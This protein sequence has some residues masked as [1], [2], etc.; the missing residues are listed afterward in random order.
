M[1][2]LQ[3]LIG[4]ELVA[5]V[6]RVVR[7]GQSSGRPASRYALDARAGYV[8]GLELGKHQER[9]VVA[10]IG[11]VVQARYVFAADSRD[12]VDDRMRSLVE[13]VDDV[14]RTHADLGPLLG[15]GAAVP[16]ALSPEGLM[17]RSP[18]FEAWTGRNVAD[19]FAAAFDVPVLL[20]NDLNSAAL[21]EHRRGAA[22]DV[23]DVVLALVWHQVSAGLIIDGSVRVGRYSRA[24][25]MSQLACSADDEMLARWPSMPEFLATAEAAHAGD[26]VARRQVEQFAR[27]AGAQIA[28][29]LIAVDPDVVVLYGPA[30]AAPRVADLVREAIRDAVLPPQD[31]PVVVAEL[32]EDA[33]VTGVLIAALE[34][35][36]Q[37]FFGDAA[38]S[39]NRLSDA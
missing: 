35:A 6:A 27:A 1:D 7:S 17:T 31:T 21:A 22:V 8:I 18:I 26:D 38:T 33:A 11:S 25:E 10:D 15:V 2:R 30:A 29:L 39:V 23:S 20:Q 34:A 28:A 3:D 13:H 37:G 24:G 32:G 4:L 14:R 16:G 9:L 36:A 19:L 5:E 12:S